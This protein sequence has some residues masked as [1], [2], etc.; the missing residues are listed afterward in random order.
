M[1]HQTA[2]W[3]G[4]RHKDRGLYPHPQ[5]SRLQ[6][7]AAPLPIQAT[8]PG[9]H[10]AMSELSSCARF[11][12]LTLLSKKPGRPTSFAEERTLCRFLI[13]KVVGGQ[14][15][16]LNAHVLIFR[17]PLHSMSGSERRHSLSVWSLRPPYTK[18]IRMM[19]MA[20]LPTAAD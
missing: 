12:Y 19:V 16:C 2:Y 10:R 9:L 1:Q 13:V 5:R 3:R 4:A 11:S 14:R 20:T 18:Q 15:A 17:F 7:A 8:A 6:H